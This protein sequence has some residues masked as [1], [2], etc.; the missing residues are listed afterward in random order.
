MNI[1]LVGLALIAAGIVGLLLL[2]GYLIDAGS[3]SSTA[4]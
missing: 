2:I 3:S 4:R 1:T